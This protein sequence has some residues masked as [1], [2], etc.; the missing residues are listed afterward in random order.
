MGEVRKRPLLN[1]YGQ[2]AAYATS[3]VLRGHARYFK[4]LL[5]S[6]GLLLTADPLRNDYRSCQ[7]TQIFMH[8]IICKRIHMQ[9]LLC[10]PIRLTQ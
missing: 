9:Y 10:G 1:A 5:M 2:A 7:G 3:L 6:S 4:G 8:D